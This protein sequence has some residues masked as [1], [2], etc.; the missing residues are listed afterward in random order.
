MGL[1]DQLCGGETAARL[2]QPT[3]KGRGHGVR[4]AGHDGE[5]A[6]WQAQ[7]ASV[8]AYHLHPGAEPLAEVMRSVRVEFDCDHPCTGGHQ[9]SGDSAVAGS[10]VEYQVAGPN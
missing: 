10:D 5:W 6:G 2:G 1:N 8:L 4:D 3:K 9:W 7:V